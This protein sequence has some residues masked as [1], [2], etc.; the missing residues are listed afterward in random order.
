MK[1]IQII[2]EH[3]RAKGHYTDRGTF[4]PPDPIRQGHKRVEAIVEIDG[5]KVTRHIDVQK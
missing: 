3:K 4:L 5:Q 1:I 2:S